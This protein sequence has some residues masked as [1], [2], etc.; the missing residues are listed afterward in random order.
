M[1][2]SLIFNSN[3]PQPPRGDTNEM[4]WVLAHA[5]GD[6]ANDVVLVCSPTP[7][8][9]KQTNPPREITTVRALCVFMRKP[10]SFAGPN[11]PATRVMSPQGSPHWLTHKRN[12][13]IKRN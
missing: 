2:I 4:A 12:L 13:L 1:S 7:R 10:L 11:S 8:V 6:Q 5:N 3:S 9:I